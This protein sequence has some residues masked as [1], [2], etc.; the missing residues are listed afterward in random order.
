MNEEYREFDDDEEE[1]DELE[2][3]INFLL[4]DITNLNSKIKNR[5]QDEFNKKFIVNFLI[6]MT[7][8]RFFDTWIDSEGKLIRGIENLFNELDKLNEGEPIPFTVSEEFQ[9]LIDDDLD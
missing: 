8:Y 7:Y 4:Q 2:S 3:R 6:F 9:N 5:S 1:L